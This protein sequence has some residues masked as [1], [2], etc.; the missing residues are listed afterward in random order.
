MERRRRKPFVDSEPMAD[1]TYRI[2]P[3][4]ERT[5]AAILQAA[6]M[7]LIEGGPDAVTH[8]TVAER[9]NVSR[10]TVYSHHP[11]REDLLRATLQTMR[12]PLAVELTGDLRIDLVAGLSGLQIDLG[13]EER[14]RVF[15]TVLARS[16][17]DPAVAA[18]RKAAIGEAMTLFRR[19]LQHGIDGGQLRADL[20]IDLAM[21]SLVGTFFFRRFLADQPVTPE[22]ITTVVDTFLEVNAPR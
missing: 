4:I 13:G 15:A 11:A 10:T 3:R 12:P 5:Q 20:D 17:H 6:A 21:A 7:L 18:V 19:V 1:E 16:H 22:I 14:M 2:D 8:A 9:A